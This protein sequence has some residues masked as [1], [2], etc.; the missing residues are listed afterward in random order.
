MW[1]VCGLDLCAVLQLLVIIQLSWLLLQR[2]LGVSQWGVYVE[3]TKRKSYMCGNAH[4]YYVTKLLTIRL[5]RTT[6]VCC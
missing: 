4:D 1:E 5:Q 3:L 2:N 6:N